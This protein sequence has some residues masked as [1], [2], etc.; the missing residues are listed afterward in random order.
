MSLNS[1][2]IS[3]NG[4]YITPLHPRESVSVIWNFEFSV[5]SS[6]ADQLKASNEMFL[7]IETGVVDLTIHLTGPWN[8][9]TYETDMTMIGNSLSVSPGSMEFNPVMLIPQN[10]RY[11]TSGNNQWAFTVN[12]YLYNY[13]DLTVE[14]APNGG[15]FYFNS[16]Q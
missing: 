14:L 6:E 15:W 3:T 12:L 4:A 2:L 7:K 11:R 16:F 8:P 13:G 10:V 9:K 5:S 1:A